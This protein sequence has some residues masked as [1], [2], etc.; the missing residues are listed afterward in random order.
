MTKD[1]STLGFY[2]NNAEQ[3]AQR[4]PVN[5]FLEKRSAFASRLKVGAKILELGCGGGHD[6]LAFL[7]QGFDVTLLDGSPEL[8]T[9]AQIRT[10]Q[11]V[12]VMDF[13]DI[14]F[15]RQFDA[16]WAS[17]SLLHVPSAQLPPVLTQIVKSLGDGGIL[18]ASF[19]EGEGD[20]EDKF[21]RHF[22]GMDNEKLK[23]LLQATGFKVESLETI[24][25]FGSDMKPTRWIWA[26]A[27]KL[28]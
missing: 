25:G 22:C 18:T 11:E 4:T 10:G 7:Q 5:S 3:F 27:V 9:L 6:A 16:V 1:N 20:W 2:A 14:S 15:D 19:K 17:A 21:G 13:S 28:I 23:N 24:E 12:L 26:D 8:A